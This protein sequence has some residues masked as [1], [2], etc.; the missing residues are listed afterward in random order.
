MIN[1]GRFTD[2]VSEDS[3]KKLGLKI[4]PHVKSICSMN[5]R[6]KLRV[7]KWYLTLFPMII[8]Q[9]SSCATFTKACHILL[10]CTW[11][12]IMM[13]TSSAYRYLLICW[14]QHWVHSYLCYWHGN[15]EAQGLFVDSASRSFILWYSWS[16]GCAPKLN[17]VEFFPTDKNWCKKNPH[18]TLDQYKRFWKPM[19]NRRKGPIEFP[20]N[21]I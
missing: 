3:T 7:H 19:P 8:L 1:T 16:V 15:F 2:D 4:L 12:W 11:I 18:Y 21:F 6:H 9:R 14:R 13:C 17:K 10:E 20:R 5:Y